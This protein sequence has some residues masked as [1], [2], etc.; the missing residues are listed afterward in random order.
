M[1]AVAFDVFARAMS[2]RG[3]RRCRGAFEGTLR[4]SADGPS[5]RLAVKWARSGTTA[6]GAVDMNALRILHAVRSDY[7][8]EVALDGNSNWLH[9]DVIRPANYHLWA[10]AAMLVQHAQSAAEEFVNDAL[11][12][13]GQDASV[14]VLATYVGP[15]EVALDVACANPNATVRRLRPAFAARFG[16][17][18]TN[19][20]SR[21]AQ[22]YERL[23]RASWCLRGFFRRGEEMKAYG[24][25][26]RR[27]RLEARLSADA[28]RAA[29]IPRAIDRG[30]DEFGAWFG[31]VAEHV[32]PHFRYLLRAAAA[33]PPAP[34]GAAARFIVALTARVRDQ[35]RVWEILRELRDCGRIRTRPGRRLDALLRARILERGARG[36]YAIHSRFRGA[37]EAL[38]R[39]LGELARRL[40][41]ARS[42]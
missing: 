34:P 10:S 19:D 5:V 31:R 24:K 13:A 3:F 27:L 6:W 21:S 8:G 36:L 29:G 4:L 16:E 23:T 30:D 35:G 22:L 17:V 20:Y 39:V 37:L 26:N 11:A 18:L 28:L 1:P 12:R 41:A 2:E 15:I 42:A 38:P 7:D 9:P 32:L 14:N 33:N 25:T 40:M